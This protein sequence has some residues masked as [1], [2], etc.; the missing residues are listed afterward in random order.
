MKQ[1]RKLIIILSIISVVIIIL[2]YTF[3]HNFMGPVSQDKTKIDFIVEPNSTYLTIANELKDEHLIKSTFGYKLYIKIFNP[4]LLKAGK[5]QLTKAMSVMDIIHLLEEGKPANPNIVR[6]TF[7]EGLNMRAIAKLIATKTNNS[8]TDIYATLTGSDYLDSLIS[9]YWFL[10]SA[11]KN[12]EIYYSLEGYLFPDTYE[13]NKQ[14]SI[15]EIFSIML[16]NTLKKLTPFKEEITNS[17][18]KIHELITLASIIELEASNSNDRA[19]V[20]GVFYNRL[21][22]SWT[23]GSDVTTYYAEKKELWVADLTDLE[24]HACNAYNTRGT[25]FTGLPIGP[26]SNPGLESIK[27]VIEPRMGQYYYFV[28]DKT[29]KTYFNVNVTGHNKTI[30][31]L[32]SRN[33]WFQY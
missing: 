27:A 3:F 1:Y 5:Y 7:R 9:K 4:E 18:Y 16:N 29:G 14:T 10:T 28:A 17:Q 6:I 20:A 30:A 23:L 19:G 11:I 21:N 26:V 22:D 13:F 15:K 32:K 8:V 12:P 25:C 33:L 31:D 2:G 24:L